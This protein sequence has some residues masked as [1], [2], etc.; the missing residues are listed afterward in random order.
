[1]SVCVLYYVAFGLESG[2]GYVIELQYIIDFGY[3][4]FGNPEILKTFWE[5]R[6]VGIPK[7]RLGIDLQI[8]ILKIFGMRFEIPFLI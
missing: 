1:M 5:S 7:F 8:S 2:F 6:K 3:M 4:K